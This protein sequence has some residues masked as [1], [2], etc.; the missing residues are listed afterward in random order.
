MLPFSTYNIPE[1]R[2]EETHTS[3][4]WLWIVTGREESG[5]SEALLQKIVSA[6]KA[7]LQTDVYQIRS[8]K[9]DPIALS[10]LQSYHPKLVISFGV[11]SSLLGIW[12]DIPSQAIRFLEKFTFIQTITLDELNQSPT[13]K[14]H[15][16][17][18]MQIYMEMNN[19]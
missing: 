18:A 12:I 7:D 15:L 4:K 2:K 14:K 1:S 6:L 17:N 16:W 5:S 11:S 3:E 13:G 19:K 9:E 8:D 10:T